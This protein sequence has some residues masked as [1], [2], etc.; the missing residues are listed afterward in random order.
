MQSSE[1]FIRATLVIARAAVLGLI[2]AITTPLPAV[3][4]DAG[5]K[6]LVDYSEDYFFYKAAK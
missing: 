6:A 3:A 2:A 4:G 1:R 5:K